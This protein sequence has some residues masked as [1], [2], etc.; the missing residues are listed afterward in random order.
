MTALHLAVRHNHVDCV[1]LLIGYRADVN[2]TDNFGFRPVHDAALYGFAECLKELLNSGAFVKGVDLHGLDYVTPLY[3]AIK[4]NFIDC[5]QALE[6]GSKDFDIHECDRLIWK[7]GS[8]NCDMNLLAYSKK[9][10]ELQILFSTCFALFCFVLFCFALFC[11]AL[12]C[13]ALF[14]FALLCFVL[15]CF[16]LL[17]FAL[18]CFALLCFALLWLCFVLF[19]FALLCFALLCFCYCSIKTIKVNTTEDGNK[20]MYTV[21]PVGGGG[22][23]PLFG[24]YMV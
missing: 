3:Y 23:I 16:A 13:F 9:N 20:N 10:G 4:H 19:C 1:K 7:L 17:C 8:T 5:V 18:L 6:V 24:E 2:A 15:F 11:F 21:Q 14:Y 22:S 12:L